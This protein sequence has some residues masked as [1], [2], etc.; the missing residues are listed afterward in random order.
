M[1]LQNFLD[2][3]LPHVKAKSKQLNIATWILETT[4]SKDAAMLSADLATE[5]RLLFHDRD[6]FEKL[7]AWDKDPAI[8]DPIVKR[9]INVLLRSIKP[10]L[11]PQELLKKLSHEESNLSF[12][13]SNFRPVI[14]GKP[15]SE[16]EIREILKNETNIEAR[17]KAWEASKEVG[18]LLAPHILSLVKLRNAAAK[19]LGYKD[20]FSMQLE[21]QEVHEKDLFDLLDHLSE[22]SESAYAH[23]IESIHKQMAQRFHVPQ[24][25]VG[26]WAWSDP[27][28]QED[29]LD[30]EELDGLTQG[31]DIIATAQR[32]YQNIKL[33]VEAILERS[34]NFERLGKN[35]HA[36]CI[37]I[38]REG[39]VRTLNNIKPTMRWLEILFHELGHGAYE[40]GY[41]TNLPWLLKEPPHMIT[42]EAMALYVGRQVYRAETLK[43]LHIGSN[44]ASL[45]EK[46]EMSLKRRQ[47]I[48][49]RWVL[50][51]T[52]FERELYR[53]PDQ[54]LNQ[55]WWRLVE[56]FQ[57]IT[58]SGSSSGCDWAAKYHICLA[59][60]YYYSYLL[61]ELF[62]SSIEKKMESIPFE[63]R[64]EF[65]R[66]NLF[67]PGNSL[68]W[69]SLI[70]QFL[71]KK[72]EAND[73]LSQFA[74]QETE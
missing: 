63:K 44:D 28:C 32:F 26:P 56:R 14:D 68:P 24:E 19:T 13:Y 31:L 27:F 45:R 73:W 1:T 57:K 49:S 38:D 5:L 62:A 59:P 4:G 58:C 39:D 2:A 15:L 61:G 7:V 52:H 34:D 12:L 22:N 29:P 65:L 3:F 17:K 20:Y 66:A 42:T 25:M 46:A 43:M 47:L 72:L 55:L 51:M 6:A 50:V 8:N 9:T 10:N 37:N 33:P 36:F 35:Q 30:T 11:V 64:G 60:V 16:N 69:D 67:E 53:N 18:K 71:G 23:L 21:L 54:D 41:S 74:S 48:F 40:L 70:K